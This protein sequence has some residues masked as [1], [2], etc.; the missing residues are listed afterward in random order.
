MQWRR[1]GNVLCVNVSVH[2]MHISS[3]TQ[4]FTQA[5]GKT[6]WPLLMLK[7]EDL[8]A[9]FSVRRTGSLQVRVKSA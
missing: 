1:F 6:T 2:L 7:I 3:Y 8:R 4:G 5:C 9:V